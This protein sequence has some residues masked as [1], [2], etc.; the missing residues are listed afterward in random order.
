MYALLFENEYI[1]GGYGTTAD[2]V[3]A[4]EQAVRD[5]A[6]VLSFSAGFGVA[7]TLWSDPL[8]R[9]FQGAALAGVLPVAAASNEGDYGTVENAGPFMLTVAAGTTARR[10]AASFEAS[11]GAGI[12][13]NVSGAS[14]S[15]GA[16]PAEVVYPNA[17]AGAALCAPGALDG[18]AAA[19]VAGRVVL[20]DRGEYARAAKAAEVA[21]A[22]GVGM[23]LMN[24][25]ASEQALYV[26]A[27][28][29]VAT[30]SVDVDARAAILAAYAAAAAAG[31]NLTGRI[32]GARA[33]Y[34]AE[35]PGVAWFSSKGPSLLDDAALLKPDVLAPGVDIFAP[36]TA[37][38]GSGDATGEFLSGTSMS[39]PHVAGIAALIRSKN[40]T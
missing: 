40:P 15:W 25:P 10:Y 19:A 13:V 21:R 20:C 23:V 18:S 39:T 17:S 37:R 8:S 24:T 33:E 9:A 26:D 28:F 22:G 30:V 11:G 12:S 4:I 7:Y 1:G 31:G 14:L 3:E 2:A 34:D 6:D 35:A 16:G 5:G 29:P 32:G 38:V 36:T 27:G